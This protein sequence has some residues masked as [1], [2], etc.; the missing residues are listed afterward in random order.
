MTTRCEKSCPKYQYLLLSNRIVE[1]SLP[2]PD[3]L[4]L[5]A[6]TEPSTFDEEEAAAEG[7]LAVPDNWAKPIDGGLERNTVYTFFCWVSLSVNAGRGVGGG[8]ITNQK[9]IT[10][11]PV[12]IL[13][14]TA[15]IRHLTEIEYGANALIGVIIYIV[16]GN[17]MTHVCSTN[18]PCIPAERKP[19]LH[20]GIAGYKIVVGRVSA[21]ELRSPQRCI[22]K[23]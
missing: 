10:N 3:G 18:W 1:D 5:E 17:T 9:G 11:Y 14:P 23:L 15:N 7:L 2:V 20:L 13:S 21:L 16:A 22:R 19:N 6:V 4:A 12:G 8:M